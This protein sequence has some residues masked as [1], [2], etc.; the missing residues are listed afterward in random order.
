MALQS[1]SKKGRHDSSH[2][3][4]SHSFPRAPSHVRYA[5]AQIY[6]NV[7]SPAPI[8]S[9][10]I[11]LIEAKA[12]T[13]AALFSTYPTPCMRRHHIAIA[14]PIPSLLLIVSPPPHSVPIPSA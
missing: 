2:S 6:Q 7:M 9:S 1:G 4:Y 12:T 10:L 3:Q 8:S 13:L 11:S 5:V 14:T